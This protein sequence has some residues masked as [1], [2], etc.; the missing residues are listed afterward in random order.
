M[1]FDTYSNGSVTLKNRIVMAPMT[2]CRCDHR[3][4]VPNESV[5]EYYRQRATAGLIISEGVPVS[6]R[7]R[8]YLGTAALWNDAQ[9][10]GWQKVN[11]GVH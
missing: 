11:A 1:L 9:A 2:R 6:D 10:A 5:A 3:D 4:A 8:G 7:A